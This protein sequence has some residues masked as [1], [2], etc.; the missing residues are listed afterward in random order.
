MRRRSWRIVPEIS[1]LKESAQE[2]CRFIRDANDFVRCLAIEFEIEF[3][4]GAIV[5]PVAKTFQLAA[6]EAPLGERGASNSDADPGRLPGDAAFFRDRFG[7]SDDTARN[8]TLPAFILAR[9]DKDHI[10]FADVLSTIHRL[11]RGEPERSHPRIDHRNFDRV[12]HFCP[13]LTNSRYSSQNA[14]TFFRPELRR[15][16]K[17]SERVSG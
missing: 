16:A 7:R 2:C 9:E 11:L 3:G 6:P 17:S 12:R 14:E 1:R 4:F 8:E 15:S 5:V 10:P 13:P